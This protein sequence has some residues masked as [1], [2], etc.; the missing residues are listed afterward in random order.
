MNHLAVRSRSL[1]SD[2]PFTATGLGDRIHAVTCAW[3]YSQ[4]HGP[5][6]LHIDQTKMEGGQF[7]NKPE[8]WREILDLLSPGH[9]QICNWQIRPKT[10]SEWLGLLHDAGIEPK[11]WRYGDFPGTHDDGLGIDIVPYIRDIPRLEAPD[12]NVEL[13]ERF[14]TEQWDANGPARRHPHQHEIRAQYRKRGLY[15]LTVGGEADEPY[16]TSLAHAA[17]A[18]SRAE[19]H[20][21]VDSGFMHLALL[22]L[23]RPRIH[24]PGEAHSHHLKRLRCG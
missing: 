17:Y 11:L 24:I 9:V 3:A 8:S 22:Y 13:P 21:G 1:N 7:G 12:L 14:A 16:R 10:E 2:R 23:P 6:T 19:C 20:V 15:L 4:A 5:V 18:M